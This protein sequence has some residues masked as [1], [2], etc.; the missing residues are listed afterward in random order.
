MSDF[1]P[2]TYNSDPKMKKIEDGIFHLQ[3]VD[4]EVE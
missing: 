3:E 2:C 1:V 4:L